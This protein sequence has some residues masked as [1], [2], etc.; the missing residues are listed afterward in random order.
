MPLSC[1]RTASTLFEMR[2]ISR[3]LSRYLRIS[4]SGEVN[5]FLRALQVLHVA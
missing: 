2:S 3:R 5:S 1:G 4:S